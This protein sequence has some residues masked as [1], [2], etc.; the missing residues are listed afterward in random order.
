[1][2][3]V[4]G[5]ERWSFRKIKSLQDQIESSS[6]R[7]I[8]VVAPVSQNDAVVYKGSVGLVVVSVSVVVAFAA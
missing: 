1:M 6:I 7:D 4:N 2:R 5:F 3:N 8:P